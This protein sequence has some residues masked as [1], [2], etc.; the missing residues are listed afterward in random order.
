MQRVVSLRLSCKPRV[1]LLGDRPSGVFRGLDRQGISPSDPS[2]YSRSPSSFPSSLRAT[3]S[4]TIRVDP[5]T[6]AAI[7]GW[8]RQDRGQLVPMKHHFSQPLGICKSRALPTNNL[9]IS[10]VG[11]QGRVLYLQ[12]TTSKGWEAG[13]PNQRFADVGRQ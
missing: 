2:T 6:L 4:C 7:R 13:T 9:R 5:G 1:E 3:Q 11:K 10:R 12:I 8:E